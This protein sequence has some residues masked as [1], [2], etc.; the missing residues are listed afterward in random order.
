M[1]VQSLESEKSSKIF[2][3]WDIAKIV[4]ESQST[5]K[6]MMFEKKNHLKWNTTS[7]DMNNEAIHD[8]PLLCTSGL[9]C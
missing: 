4:P 2:P 9:T 7:Q 3:E 6:F 5:Q 1:A 8:G